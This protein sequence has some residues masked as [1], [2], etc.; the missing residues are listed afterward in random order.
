MINVPLHTIYP[1]ILFHFS[2]F[3]VSDVASATYRIKGCTN[4]FTK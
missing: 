2:L 1:M 4:I 3:R